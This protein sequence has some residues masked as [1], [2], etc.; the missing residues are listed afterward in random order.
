VLEVQS[1]PDSESEVTT[2][3]KLLQS[4]FDM[5]RFFC[6]I[7]FQVSLCLTVAY[8]RTSNFGS[9]Y[10][11]EMF[12]MFIIARPVFIILYSWTITGINVH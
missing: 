8:Y 11:L 12:L 3:S 4:L 7:V 2:P 6:V 10:M 1:D 5:F 9:K